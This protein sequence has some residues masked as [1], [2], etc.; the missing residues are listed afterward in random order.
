MAVERFDIDTLMD[1]LVVLVIVITS[2]TRSSVVIGREVDRRMG[3]MAATVR[4][5]DVACA[6]DAKPTAVVSLSFAEL[7]VPA[8]DEIA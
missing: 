2:V 4:P 5:A 8:A 7:L 6:D 1:D 3:D